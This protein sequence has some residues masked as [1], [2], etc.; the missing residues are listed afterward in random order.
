MSDLQLL[1]LLEVDQAVAVCMLGIEKGWP[2]SFDYVKPQV[3]A[4]FNAAA[5]DDAPLPGPFNHV[6]LARSSG[7]VYLA[8]ADQ[9]TTVA[10]A[11]AKRIQFREDCRQGHIPARVADA[12]FS[13]LKG[14]EPALARFVDLIPEGG[15]Q[16]GLSDAFWR[17]RGADLAGPIDGWVL[18]VARA[19]NIA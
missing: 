3:L 1:N 2:A 6:R 14:Y 4:A 5:A 7:G 13:R 12:A 19:L 17:R 18:N 11:T 8:P 9:P 10:L 15:R 16:R